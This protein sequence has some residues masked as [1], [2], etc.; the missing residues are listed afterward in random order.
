MPICS[1]LTAPLL[2]FQGGPMPLN[3]RQRRQ[4]CLCVCV[5]GQQ[6][7][8]EYIN[9][10]SIVVTSLC[11]TP[12]QLQLPL[13]LP[14]PIANIFTQL[15]LQLAPNNSAGRSKWLL[16]LQLI[17]ALNLPAT[18]LKHHLFWHGTFQWC[19]NCDLYGDRLMCVTHD[20]DWKKR[21]IY[22]RFCSL[23]TGDFIYLALTTQTAA[24]KFPYS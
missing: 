8:E 4:T 11:P 18:I 15:L 17:L 5:G 21:I 16:L 13:L 10:A 23:R 3:Y 14:A 2:T 19:N 7:C 22:N 9:L 20:D 24:K 6:C 12:F 1:T